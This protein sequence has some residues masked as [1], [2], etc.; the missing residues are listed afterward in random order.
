[1]LAKKAKKTKKN[2]N[3]PLIKGLCIVEAGLS[4][5]IS[6]FIIARQAVTVPLKKDTVSAIFFR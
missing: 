6:N 1:M 3:M 2:I 5:A 4:V